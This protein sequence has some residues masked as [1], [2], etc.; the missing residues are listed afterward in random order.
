MA[1]PDTYPEIPSPSGASFRTLEDT[2]STPMRTGSP[3]PV[4]HVNERS[5][6]LDRSGDSGHIEYGAEQAERAERRRRSSSYAVIN[7]E[8]SSGVGVAGIRG[9]SNDDD[10]GEF[11]IF[12]VSSAQPQFAE[13]AHW[14]YA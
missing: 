4:Q 8:T 5:R 7:T 12:L 13:G 9:L 6:L 10:V 1:N 3:A 2:S 14:V 11:S